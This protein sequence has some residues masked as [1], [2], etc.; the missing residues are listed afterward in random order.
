MG[1]PCVLFLEI[2]LLKCTADPTSTPTQRELD[3]ENLELE[4]NTTDYFQWIRRMDNLKEVL[5]NS[6]E[7]PCGAIHP[8]HKEH[9]TVRKCKG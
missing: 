2:N 6:N 5:I 1:R 3:A 8:F 7:L 4:G 9:I